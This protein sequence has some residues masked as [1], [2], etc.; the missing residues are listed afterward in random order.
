MEECSAN[1]QS[2]FVCRTALALQKMLA[3]LMNMRNCQPI[4]ESHW[5]ALDLDERDERFKKG[6][7][8]R[9]YNALSSR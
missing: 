3:K 1:S 9:I 8:N 6:K 7:M 4:K 2:L 5:H